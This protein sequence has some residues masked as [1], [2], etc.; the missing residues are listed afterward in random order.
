[1]C[2]QNYFLTLL[3]NSKTRR[4]LTGWYVLF[5]YLCDDMRDVTDTLNDKVIEFLCDL[6]SI[7]NEFEELK[8]CINSFQEN[9]LDFVVVPSEGGT[10]DINSIRNKLSNLYTIV[11]K[12][13]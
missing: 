10:N 12:L 8:E 4:F 2:P 13:R 6:K 11:R 5:N 3:S 9:E 7:S 1:M